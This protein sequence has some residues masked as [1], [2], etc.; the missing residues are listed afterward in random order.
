MSDVLM[1]TFNMPISFYYMIVG[2]W[3]FGRTLCHIAYP[4]FV[5]P[6]YVS[7]WTIMLISIDRCIAARPIKKS[8]LTRKQV[9]HS[10]VNAGNRG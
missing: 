10:T 4:T 2:D 8:G 3:V 6:V 7:S 5:L 1:L 9:R